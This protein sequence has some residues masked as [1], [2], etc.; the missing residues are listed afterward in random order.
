M[1]KKKIIIF[2]S[3]ITALAITILFIVLITP[4]FKKD[5][6]FLEHYNNRLLIFEN[7]NKVLTDVDVAFVG[8]SITE[9]YDVKTY[10]PN[11]KVTNRGIGGDTSHGLFKRLKISLYDISPKVI[12]LCIGGNNL[13][14]MLQD[15][16]NIVKDIKD[17]LPDSKLIISSLY[18]TSL[19][20]TDRNETIVT[21]NENLKI[22]AST[23]S[24]T[25]FDSHTLMTNIE[26][27]EFDTLYTSDGLH[28][29]AA[30]YQVITENLSP[31]IQNLLS[32]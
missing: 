17:N 9:G 20:F 2:S 25:Y 27:K 19:L 4:A 31:I 8:D 24:C 26:T 18:P 14:S 10:Y 12:V 6:I 23:Y 28:P 21:I 13:E 15:Y 3:V 22:L 5:D 7:E 11:L 1:D 16:E 29:N 32:V 30:A